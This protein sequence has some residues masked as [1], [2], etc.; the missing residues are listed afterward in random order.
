MKVIVCGAG[1]IGVTTA[2]YLAR[3]GHDVAVLERRPHPGVETSFANAGQVSWGYAT[4]WAAPGVPAKALRWLFQRHAP[5]ILRPRLDPKLWSWLARMLGQCSAAAYARNKGSMVSLARFS[6]A[7]LKNLRAELDLR[8][9]EGTRGL[10]QLFR[11]QKSLDAAA[12]DSAVLTALDVPH[13]LLDRGG[14]LD[15]ES[16]LRFAQA[17]IA[18]GLH[19]PG[20][21]TGDCHLFT[22]ALARHAA[23]R[24][25]KFLFD[26]A[27]L[28]FETSGDRV[29]FVDT[30]IGPLAADAVVV[31]LASR[32]SGM[33]APLGLRIPVYPVKGYS[34]TLPITDADSAPISTIMD[35]AHKVAITRLGER[36]RVAGMAELG[37][38]D[39]ALRERPCD[40]LM[41]VLRTLFPR[42]GDMT[43]V[44]FWT[45]LR[46][47]TPDGP[48]ILGP[49]R[50]AN[51]FLNTGHGTLGWTM[52]CGS[53]RILAEMVSGVE[54]SIPTDAYAPS[55]YLPRT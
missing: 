50:Y 20:D 17:Q 45:G 49:A 14:C 27:V 34:A 18:G 37:G 41:H 31:A 7:C 52:A 46:A 3:M 21:E 15:K 24:G 54:P 36:I 28:G 13:A 29:T 30:D 12:A 23:D 40:T 33:V 35:E 38:D 11:D 32:T 47:M 10:L 25:V 5:L 6:A 55:R 48:P 2:F 53:A 1:V 9:D 44:Q 4:P 19:L 43:S 42:G 22:K 8:Y 39:L 26:T 16:G 51:L